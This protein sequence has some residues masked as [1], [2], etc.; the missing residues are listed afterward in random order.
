M[1]IIND[2]PKVRITIPKADGLLN[3]DAELLGYPARHE[4]KPTR[5][6]VRLPNGRHTTAPYGTC[7][8]LN[9]AARVLLAY[10]PAEGKRA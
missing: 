3:T 8:A 7:E 5:I 9:E 6:E 1:T 4:G 10:Q 2:P